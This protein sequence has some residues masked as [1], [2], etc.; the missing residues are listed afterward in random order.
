V[1]TLK[2]LILALC[3]FVPSCVRLWIW[4][5]LGMEVG[6]GCRIGMFSLVVA[7]TIKLGPGVVIEPFAMIYGPESVELGERCRISYFVTILG[8]GRLVMRPQSYVIIGAMIDTTH[9]CTLGERAAVGARCILMTHGDSQLTYT[10]GYTFRNGPVEIGA[11]CYLGFGVSVYPNVKIGDRSVIAPGVLV[12]RSIEA[13]QLLLP[14]QPSS[15][16]R[17]TISVGLL[18][19]RNPQEVR[20][21]KIESDFRS[22]VDL[23]GAATLDESRDDY[24]V[25]SLPR[26]RKVVLL[27]TAGA[28]IPACVDRRTVVWTPKRDRDYPVPTFDFSCLT[29]HGGRT[30]LAEQ[31]AAFLCAHRAVH[32]VFDM[33]EGAARRA[34]A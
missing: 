17:Q 4:R 22:L 5:L 13:D 29:V 2:H 15:K 33:P 14:P 31:I 11:D 8:S 26:R 19:A 12:T 18:R 16:T 6:P 23:A 20:A 3:T 21:E 30:A 9:G 25:L 1:R 27:R 34:A 32:F 7:D 24:W 28:D 10:L